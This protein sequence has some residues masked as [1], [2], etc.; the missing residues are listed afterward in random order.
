MEERLENH[1]TFRGTS[2]VQMQTALDGVEK[3]VMTKIYKA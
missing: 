2:P 3:Y 1:N